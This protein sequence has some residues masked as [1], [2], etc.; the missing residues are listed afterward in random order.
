MI[1]FI[2]GLIAPYAILKDHGPAHLAWMSD[3]GGR[4]VSFF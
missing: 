4:R 3:A 2:A 1:I